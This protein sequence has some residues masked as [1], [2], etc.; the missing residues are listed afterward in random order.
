M[1]R[2]YAFMAEPESNRRNINTRLEQMG[3]VCMANKMWGNWSPE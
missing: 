1:G 3:G 2:F